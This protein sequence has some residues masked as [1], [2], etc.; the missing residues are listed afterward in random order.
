[1]SKNSASSMDVRDREV[2]YLWTKGPN[3]G[4]FEVCLTQKP[5]SVHGEGQAGVHPAVKQLLQSMTK[6]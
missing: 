3:P 4:L 1:M 2:A 5:L 6:D